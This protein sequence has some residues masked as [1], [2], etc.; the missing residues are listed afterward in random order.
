MVDQRLTRGRT[1]ADWP[2]EVEGHIDKALGR[3]RTGRLQAV[4]DEP[5]PRFVQRTDLL[6]GEIDAFHQTAGIDPLLA[7]VPALNAR[8]IEQ[9]LPHIAAFQRVPADPA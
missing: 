1:H 5:Y 7:S 8:R 3:Q 2:G 4:N 9:I 6:G